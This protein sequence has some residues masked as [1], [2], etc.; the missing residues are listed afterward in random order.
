[1][2]LSDVY[3]YIDEH[4]DAYIRSLQEMVRQP[5]IAAQSVGMTEMAANVSDGLR[6]LGAEPRQI[7]TGGGF[8]VV[9][10]EFD[11][12][13]GKTLSFYDHY[14]VQPAEPYEQWE[15][16]P[17]AGEI[18]DGRIW[19]R[20]VADNKGNLAARLAAIDAWQQVRGE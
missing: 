7:D 13:G 11:G 12:K 1:S 6:S 17:W 19:A 4:R 2:D 20:G 9:Y 8:P 15:S 14:D 5:S 3:Q 16:D 10:A 18:R